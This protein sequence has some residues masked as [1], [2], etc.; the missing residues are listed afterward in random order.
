MIL[1]KKF[2]GTTIRRRMPYIRIR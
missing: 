2:A 1:D